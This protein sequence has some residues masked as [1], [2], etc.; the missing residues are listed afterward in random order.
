M[1][2]AIESAAEECGYEVQWEHQKEEEDAPERC[3]EGPHGEPCNR[4]VEFGE[5]PVH[6]EVGPGAAA[7]AYDRELRGEGIIIGW[8]D[9]KEEA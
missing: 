2:R 6:G 9:S 4:I 1:G 3:G 8:Q 7:E 5:C